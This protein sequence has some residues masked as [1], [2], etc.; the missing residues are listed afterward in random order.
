[1]PSNTGN[2]AGKAQRLFLR[3]GG[4]FLLHICFPYPPSMLTMVGR[5]CVL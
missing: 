3:H 5:L 4:L 1:M 2:P